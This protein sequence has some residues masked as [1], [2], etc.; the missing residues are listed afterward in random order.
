MRSLA[1]WA[2]HATHGL[3]GEDFLVLASVLLERFIPISL[4]GQQSE[5]Q[6]ASRVTSS[7]P[8]ALRPVGPLCTAIVLVD[9]LQVCDTDLCLLVGDCMV[10]CLLPVNI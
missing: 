9:Q 4:R 2:A 5:F 3:F 6:N 1:I 10:W 7:P 8:C